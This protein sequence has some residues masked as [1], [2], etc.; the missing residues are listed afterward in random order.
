MDRNPVACW[1]NYS[2]HRD[3]WEPHFRCSQVEGNSGK[4]PHAFSGQPAR[5]V[6]LHSQFVLLLCGSESTWTV[7]PESSLPAVFPVLTLSTVYVSASFSGN[8]CLYQHFRLWILMQ[9]SLHFSSWGSAML[10]THRRKFCTD[11]PLFLI[12][13]DAQPWYVL[14]SAMLRRGWGGEEWKVRQW[15]KSLGN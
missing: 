2:Q 14:P 15:T 8:Q 6:P 3:G 13:A 5:S 4:I 9:Q 11:W 7:P 1:T 12:S 10:Q